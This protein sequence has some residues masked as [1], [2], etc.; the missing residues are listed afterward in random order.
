VVEIRT[1]IKISAKPVGFKEVQKAS[2]GV[3]QS[4]AKAIASQAKGFV[5]LKAGATAVNKEINKLQSV[6]QNLAK[7]QLKLNSA[8]EKVG[9]KGSGAYKKLAQELSGVE[10][11]FSQIGRLQSNL[12]RAFQTQERWS[13]RQGFAQGL[14]QGM[15]PGVATF[16]QRGHGMP[17]QM[18][19]MA[20]GAGIRG[21]VGVAGRVGTGLA[22]TAFTGAQSLVTA[23]QGIPGI[24]GALAAPIARGMEQAQQSLQYEQLK[25][26]T[27]P[28]LGGLAM[29]RA[30]TGAGQRAGRAGRAGVQ[31]AATMELMNEAIRGNMPL[32]GGAFREAYDPEESVEM[33]GGIENTVKGAREANFRAAVQRATNPQSPEMQALMTKRLAGIERKARAEAER[34]YLG[35][36]GG[37]GVRLMGAALPETREFLAGVTG[38]G[39]GTGTELRTQN[40]G[41]TAMAAK[42]AFGIEAGVSG[43]FLGGGRRGGLVG[44][45]GQSGEMLAGAIGD[46]LKAGLQGAEVTQYVET[47]ANGI[48]E[49]Q[50]TG[51]P[52]NKE[53]MTAMTQKFGEMG[54]HGVRG[55][56]MAG[57]FRQAGIG[58]AQQGPQSVAQ[59]MMLQSM[60]PGGQRVG[61]GSQEDIEQA[62]ISLEQGK[63]GGKEAAG[64]IEQL[65]AAGGGG[66][67]GRRVAYGALQGS[68]IKMSREELML[69][70]EGPQ[71]QEQVERVQA[72][73]AQRDQG[74]MEGAGLGTPAGLVTAAEGMVSPAL[75]EQADLTNSQIATGYNMIKTMLRL[76]TTAQAVTT[77]ITEIAKPLLEAFSGGMQD[78]TNAVIANT[79]SRGVYPQVGPKE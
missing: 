79:E 64:L 46:A 63:F 33:A 73:Q 22:G 8:M 31:R 50:Q 48:N 77:K 28:M 29:Q 74:A 42:T 45:M 9:D 7:E 43:A 25:L 19:G 1:D 15:A 55:A 27:A 70:T 16:L 60:M 39:G 6:L 59:L 49:W 47:I 54:L 78:L 2:D 34:Q 69:M 66:A 44:G 5:G 37:Q 4:A 53:S 71:T 76:E 57:Q 18:A 21:G 12:E 3:A 51:I 52:M 35:D 32:T 13:R 24:G 62:L 75:K 36:I 68:G 56:A 67:E 20:V 14:V 65:V 30:M 10:K 38:A 61:Q 41:E 17:Q 40:M 26:R 58:V 72:L 11:Q 23:L